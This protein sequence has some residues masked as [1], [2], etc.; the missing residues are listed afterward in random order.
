MTKCFVGAAS[1][2]LPQAFMYAGTWGGIVGVCFLAAMS[3]FS[4]RRLAY[5]CE[6]MPRSAASATGSPFT[7]Y[8]IGEV[9]AGRAGKY[10]AWFGLT[11][12]TL[13]VCGAYVTF[14]AS[15]LAEVSKGKPSQDAWLVITTIVIAALSWLR[16]LRIV[17][18][19][20]AFGIMALITSVVVTMRSAAAEHEP[21]PFS[22]LEAFNGIEDYS[23]FLG[24]A[25]FL[26][27]I[28]TAILPLYQDMDKESLP[29]F[30]WTF[31]SSVLF[32]TVINLIFGLFV[33]EHYGTCPKSGDMLHCVQGNVINNLPKGSVKT[34]VQILLSLDLVF[35]AIVFLYPFNE[36]IE[37]ELL[38][39]PKKKAG[40][41]SV[42]EWKRN[43]LRTI[44]VIAV[45]LVAYAVGSFSLLAGFT[46]GF[47]NNFLGFILPPFFYWRL[48]A[49][50]GYWD[51]GPRV[52]KYAEQAALLVVFL[53]GLFFLIYSTK[54]SITHIIAFNKNKAKKHH[55]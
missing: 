18:V 13:G 22:K 26:Y 24:N 27:L 55:S 2:A 48:R 50:H 1:F 4:L 25:G 20:S 15:M 39:P 34:T 44:V 49:R 37:R 10:L 16:H 41:C 7:Y 46:G 54:T 28:S 51:R 6:L 5:C 32:V 40:A 33:W 52:K 19:T 21:K 17:A 45:A 31:D 38:P 47:G 43:A 12:M 3:S 23:L 35:T 30:R 29:R 53:F 8:K 14:V 11:A 36:A 42:Y 9:A